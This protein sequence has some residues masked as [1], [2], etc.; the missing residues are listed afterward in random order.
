MR[1]GF[2]QFEP[3]FG[4]KAGNL[5]KVEQALGDAR[6]DLM[7]LPELFSTG[8]GFA[9]PDEVLEMAEDLTSGPTVTR[10]QA[11]ATRT[12]TTIAAGIAER[13]GDRT[14]NSGV[15]IAPGQSTPV[16]IYR[17]LH[18]FGRE[19]ELFSP[20]DR[21]PR[22]VSVSG[23]QLGIEVCFDHFFPELARSLALQGAQVICHPANL[24]L[25]Y[26]QQTT[27]ARALENGVF[28]ILCNRVGTE[29]Q[30]GRE[31]KF[32]GAS[33]IVG[34]RGQVLCQAGADE[35]VVK[36]V[37]IDPNAALDKCVFPGNDL[38]KDR[39]PEMYGPA[40]QRR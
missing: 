20:G 39:R 29:Q 17:K 4:D 40:H 30:A 38:L 28:W 34:P 12:G 6:A 7:T 18:L 27:V 37:E 32:T 11:L 31:L 24:V 13:D 23:V 26:A 19:K 1:A 3:R 10:L 16:L 14:F 2:F 36:V 5:A 35:E 33:Q 22:V 15:I 21:R 8:Y 9:A 25:R